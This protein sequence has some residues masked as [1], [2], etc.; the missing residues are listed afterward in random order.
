MLNAHWREARWNQCCASTFSSEIFQV[1]CSG[2]WDFRFKVYYQELKHVN[3]NILWRYQG[4]TWNNRA[5]LAFAVI[6][7]NF[8][9]CMFRLLVCW[10]CLQ[11]R[12]PQSDLMERVHVFYEYMT[13]SAG[14]GRL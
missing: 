7:L 11:S 12:S 10:F 3:V 13:S 4:C 6:W 1:S 5:F 2:D 8:I 14:F 9:Y